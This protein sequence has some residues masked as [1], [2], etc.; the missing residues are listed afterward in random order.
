MLIYYGLVILFLISSAIHLYDYTYNYDEFKINFGIVEPG[1]EFA[2]FKSSNQIRQMEKNHDDFHK[3][4]N[5]WNIPFDL[6]SVQIS[7]WLA[8]L[9][10][11]LFVWKNLQILK[12]ETAE[13]Y[14]YLKK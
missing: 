4:H 8:I 9:P 13:E 7:M 6:N 14:I 1:F 11:T 2:E 10:V 3:G 5:H 12:L